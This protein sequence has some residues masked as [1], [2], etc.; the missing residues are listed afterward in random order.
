MNSANSATAP[1][2]VLPEFYSDPNVRP[3][4]INGLFNRSAGHYDWI[5]SVLSFGTDK[6]YR[7]NALRVAGLKPGMQLLDVATGT[8]LVAEAAL[9]LGLPPSNII[10]IDPSEGMLAENR[11][12]NGAIQLIQGKGENLPFEN[13]RFDFIS[14]G[15]ALR[16]VASLD[17]LFAEFHRVLKPGGR[18]LVMEISRPESRVTFRIMQFYMQ[19]I[20]PIIARVRTSNPDLVKLMQYYWAT[21]AECVPPKDIVAALQAAS[22]KDVRRKTMGPVLNDY[23]AQKKG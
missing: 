10:G 9:Q 22:F 5:S 1:H 3:D 15:Y 13:N 2:P 19:K 16:H 18:V 7:R 23:M 20:V 11:K 12:K 6:S 17:A 4:F 21:I 8:G 14:M